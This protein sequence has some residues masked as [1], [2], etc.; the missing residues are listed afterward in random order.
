MRSNQ[1]QNFGV[2]CK[3]GLVLDCVRTPQSQRL[4]TGRGNYTPCTSGA[5]PGLSLS[6]NATA[7]LGELSA[8]GGF[9]SGSIVVMAT[10]R[11]SMPHQWRSTFESN[12]S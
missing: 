10:M 2:N 12:R 5:I 8:R 6:Q 11:E 9:D 4:S 3:D 1:N 7:Q